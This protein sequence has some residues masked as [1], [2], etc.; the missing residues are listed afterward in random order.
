MLEVI[1][2]HTLVCSLV[3]PLIHS[4]WPGKRA[5]PDHLDPYKR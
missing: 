3:R 2:I 1:H 4:R 5:L